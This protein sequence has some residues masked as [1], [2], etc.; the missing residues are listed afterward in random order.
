M[1]NNKR[2][3]DGAPASPKD[4]TKKSRW[5]TYAKL[6]ND[7]LL[8]ADKPHRDRKAAEK[9]AVED[10][11]RKE[12]TEKAIV[13]MVAKRF[14]S[15][16]RSILQFDYEVECSTP[17]DDVRRDCKLLASTDT[18]EVLVPGTDETKLIGVSCSAR[19]I[20]YDQM[21]CG[22][23]QSWDIVDIVLNYS[24]PGLDLVRQMFGGFIVGRFFRIRLV[25]HG[26]LSPNNDDDALRNVYTED[27]FKKFKSII[28]VRLECDIA[29]NQWE[30]YFKQL[31]SLVEDSSVEF[32]RIKESTKG[33]F[34]DKHTRMV[35]DYEASSNPYYVK[36][37]E[38]D[39]KLFV[40]PID[41][42]MLFNPDE[43]K[44]THVASSYAGLDLD[45]CPS[46]LH[47]ADLSQRGSRG[48]Y[49]EGA[50]RAMSTLF[51][52]NMAYGDIS[53]RASLSLSGLLDNIRD[54]IEKWTLWYR[55]LIFASVKSLA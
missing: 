14:L 35:R 42:A 7:R 44:K 26:S 27:Q 55:F 4:T 31:L 54:E 22:G 5:E 9:K 12:E 32:K 29:N 41:A 13:A 45:L 8:A 2:K 37:K 52:A 40:D 17:F 34:V 28:A 24:D 49:I 3:S 38:Y 25:V 6:H 47:S 23:L 53:C 16:R 10:A 18:V 33:P 36:C 51:R 20:L 50:A 30:K 39:E 46:S 1:S 11:A 15:L 21:V 19:S 43:F 48:S